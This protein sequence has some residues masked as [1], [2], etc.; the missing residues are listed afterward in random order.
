MNK[1]LA[2]VLLLVASHSDAGSESFVMAVST[3]H[4]PAAVVL[5][6]EADYV[7]VPIFITSSE[8]DPLRNIENVQRLSDKLREAVRQS[9]NVKLRQGT[10][11][12]SITQGEES[13]FS[14]SYRS[15]NAASNKSLFLAAPLTKSRDV[16]QAARELIVIGQSVAKS[17]QARVTY[18]ATSLGLESP[19]RFR[20]RLLALIQNDVE[21]VRTSLGNPKAFEV[22]GLESPV[23]VMQ[24]DDR[25]V[26]VYIPYRLKVGQ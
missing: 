14:S 7:A 11:S 21:Q 19:E 9:P 4:I 23:V 1:Y 5:E 3:G 18:G 20:L 15:P 22:S 24:R 10:V 16:F 8:K 2:F 25:N 6:V 17:D 13:S 12:L 26:V